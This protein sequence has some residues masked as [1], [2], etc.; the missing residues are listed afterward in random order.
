[1]KAQ[2][3]QTAAEATPDLLYSEAEDDLRAAVRSLLADR[4]DTPV[5]AR[6]RRVRHALRPRSCGARSAPGWASP[7]CSSPRSSAGRAPRTARPPWSWRRSAARSRR[8]RIL[9]SSVIATETLLA[10]DAERR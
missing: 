8:S 2:T 3:A 10:L 4:A 7:G 5:R 1:M 9:T 6:A